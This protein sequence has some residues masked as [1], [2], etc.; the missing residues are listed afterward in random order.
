MANRFIGDSIRLIHDLISYLYRTKLPG[1]LLCL[2][3]EKAFDSVDW[4]CMF[5]VLRAFGFGPDIYQWI[6]TFYKGTK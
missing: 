1:S 3:I 5:E 6:S 2:D 4:N